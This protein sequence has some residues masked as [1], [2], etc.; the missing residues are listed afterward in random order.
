[1]QNG[2]YIERWDRAG[3]EAEECETL[4]DSQSMFTVVKIRKRIWPHDIIRVLAPATATSEE[5]KQLKS[6]GAVPA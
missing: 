3:K 5:I 4:P 1:M 6:L 2:W